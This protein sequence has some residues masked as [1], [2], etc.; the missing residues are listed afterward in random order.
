MILVEQHILDESLSKECDN[1]MWK[2]K[3]VY[4][5]ALYYIRQYYFNTDKLLDPVDCYKILRGSDAYKQL[6]D[7]VSKSIIRKA[8][9]NYESYFGAFKSYK[10]TPSKFNNRPEIP[11]YLDVH[12]GRFMVIYTLE[13][14]NH[15]NYK[16]DGSLKLSKTNIMVKPQVDFK[17]IKEITITKYNYKYV[18][19]ISYDTEPII[20]EHTISE[21]TGKKVR[22]KQAKHEFIK[23]NK[24]TKHAAIDLGV[25]NLCTLTFEHTDKPLIYNGKPLKS[26]NQRWN[27]RIA[28]HQSYLNKKLKEYTSNKIKKETDKRNRRVKDY[29]HKIST[30]LVNQLVSKDVTDLVIGY[31][32]GWKQDI[33]LGK[34]N[35]QKFVN[36]PYLKLIDMLKYKCF[37]KGI[38][39]ILTEESYTSKCSFIDNESLNFHHKYMGERKHRGLFVSKSGFKYNADV[40]GSYNILRKVIPDFKY[41]KGINALCPRLVNIR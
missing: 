39:V 25:N 35:N 18:L 3:N 11:G 40:N 34:V 30:D 7:K 19:N 23:T 16:K 14:I 4:N 38:T 15:K 31:N 29:L 21:K 41:I 8:Y 5:S 37:L 9:S 33:S 1:L 12:E 27:K 28:K 32:S 36:I 24:P 6:P 26:I 20:I 10:Q 22:V 2:S 13:A 17:Q